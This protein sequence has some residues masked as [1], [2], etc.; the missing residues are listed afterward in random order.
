MRARD[1]FQVRMDQAHVGALL[2]HALGQFDQAQGDRIGLGRFVERDQA[3]VHQGLEEVV[4]SA[5]I[6]LE[7]AGH[8]GDA[9]ACRRG[10]EVAQHTQA[11]DQRAYQFFGGFGCHSEDREFLSPGKMKVWHIAALR[12]TPPLSPRAVCA[13][14]PGNAGSSPARPGCGT[15]P[16]RR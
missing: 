9:H 5:G 2:Q 13:G 8:P 3:L 14:P 12:Y 11:A 1:L 10:A 4:A 15:N 6:E 7:V 16:A